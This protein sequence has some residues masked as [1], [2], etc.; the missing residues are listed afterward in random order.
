MWEFFHAVTWRTDAPHSFGLLIPFIFNNDLLMVLIVYQLTHD[1]WLLLYCITTAIHYSFWGTAYNIHL[2]LHILPHT[3]PKTH[4]LHLTI[5][6]PT[7]VLTLTTFLI[8]I[9]FL[10]LSRNTELFLYFFYLVSF[11][12]STLSMTMN[13]VDDGIYIICRWRKE[14]LDSIIIFLLVLHNVPYIF[15]MHAIYIN[16]CRL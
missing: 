3:L 1:W 5:P 16:I 8:L 2:I 7:P 14:V 15:F 10:S 9:F 6:P 11:I 13:R 12:T 4:V